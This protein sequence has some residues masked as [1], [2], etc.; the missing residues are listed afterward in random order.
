[1]PDFFAVQLQRIFLEQKTAFNKLL[2]SGMSISAHMTSIF[3]L[4]VPITPAIV[5]YY[6]FL[7]YSFG[8]IS[9]KQVEFEKINIFLGQREEK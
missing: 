7:P 3:E 9:R 4:V 5:N 1:M 6:K 8:K 2:I